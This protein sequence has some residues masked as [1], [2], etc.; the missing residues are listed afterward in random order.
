MTKP[1]L[2][3]GMPKANGLKLPFSLIHRI[4]G[5]C[6]PVVLALVTGS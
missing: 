3:G 5:V 4:K 2:L 6:L 1:S